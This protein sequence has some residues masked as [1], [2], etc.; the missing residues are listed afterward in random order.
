[1]LAAKMDVVWLV[2]PQDMPKATLRLRGMMGQF[3]S[4]GY[5]LPVG[6]AVRHFGVCLD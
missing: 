6:A 2:L 3:V 5:C 4:I 1:M